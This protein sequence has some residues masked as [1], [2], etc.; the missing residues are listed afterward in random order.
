MQPLVQRFRI[1]PQE[2]SC[3]EGSVLKK[4]LYSF[5]FK[6]SGSFSNKFGTLLL[7]LLVG[8]GQLSA[9]SQKEK[10][11]S[12]LVKKLD[13]GYY[14][15]IQNSETS[16]VKPIVF[17][18][19][20]QNNGSDVIICEKEEKEE[21]ELMSSKK[22][23]EIGNYSTPLFGAY[24]LGDFYSNS[25]KNVSFHTSYSSYATSSRYLVFQVFRL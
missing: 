12:S 6:M 24:T 5:V 9:H 19:E 8:F 18:P 13:Q 22:Y 23:L 25:K 4:M 2:A 11:S 17:G 14:N 10:I 15:T 21:D 7:L 16:L 3:Q 1:V 20:K